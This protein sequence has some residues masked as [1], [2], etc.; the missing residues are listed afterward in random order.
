M[1]TD[2]RRRSPFHTFTDRIAAA[3]QL[4]TQLGGTAAAVDSRKCSA[5]D[6][7]E[8]FSGAIE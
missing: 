5:C 6:L 4:K 2:L 1:L 8:N 7:R 3:F